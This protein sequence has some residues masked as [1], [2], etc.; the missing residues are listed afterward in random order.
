MGAFSVFPPFPSFYDRSGNPLANGSIFIGNAGQS[1]Q[2]SPKTAYWDAALTIPAQ[3]PIRTLNGYP[4]RNGSPASV[5]VDGDYSILV[6]DR[7]GTV[8]YSSMHATSRF[9]ASVISVSSVTGTSLLP[10]NT[11]LQSALDLITDE[12]SGA[13]YVGWLQN[14]AGATPRSLLNKAQEI[15]SVKDYGAVGDGTTDDTLA[16]Q[17]AIDYAAT[18]VN[19]AANFTDPGVAILFPFGRYLISSTLVITSGGIGLYGDPSRGAM[20]TTNLSTLDMFRVG[21]DD[22]SA[23]TW[24]VH[25]SNLLFHASDEENLGVVAI[26][27]Y[28]TFAGSVRWCHFRNMYEGVVGHRMNRWTFH[29]CSFW[30]SR[31]STVAKCSMRFFGSASGTGGGLHISDCEMAGGGNSDPS[32]DSH[33]IFEE[34]DGAYVINTHTRDCNHAV[35]I[36]PNGTTGKNIID[37]LFFANCYWDN[38][39]Q[40]NVWITGSVASG[41]RYQFIRFVGCYFRG[42]VG[43]STNCLRVDVS[44]AGTFTNRLR[45]ILVANSELRQASST[46]VFIRGEASGFLEPYAVVFSGCQFED[47]NYGGAASVSALQLESETI[48]IDGCAFDKDRVPSDR[49]IRANLSNSDGRNPSF[50]CESNDFSKANCTDY[51]VNFT[52]LNSGVNLQLSSNIFPGVGRQIDQVYKTKTV[53]NLTKTIWDLVVSPGSAGT[54]EVELTGVTSDGG[55]AATYTWT[56]GFRRN[57]AGTTLST[58]G[59][60]WTAGLAWNPDALPTPPTATLAVNTLQV[61]ATGPAATTAGSFVVGR[62]YRIAVVGSTDFTL[63]GAAN[64]NV[65]TEFVATGIGAGTGTAFVVMEWACAVRLNMSR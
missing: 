37:S 11:D 56:T 24:S 54:A 42:T 27:G 16:I 60:N 32:V 10:F 48:V 44:N 8:V 64:N 57:G 9:A 59:A 39:S 13:A 65:G 43:A 51:P 61:Q 14:G 21:F 23:N 7:Q 58:G 49:I 47:N 26:R 34:C 30:Q 35:K 2:A 41:G 33:M 15:I 31:D 62:T 6:R 29:A 40:Y 22:D 63:V 12:S 19:P 28:R 17:K 18:L 4:V 46:A 45:G 50:L 53:D 25:F 52:Q 3:Q 55:I 5:Y 36:A 1:A 38:N 20:V